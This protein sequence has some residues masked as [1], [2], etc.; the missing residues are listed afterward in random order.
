[1]VKENHFR[2]DRK[3]FFNFWKTIYGFAHTLDIR[4]SESGNGQNP[5]GAGIRQHSA[6]GILL[7]PEFG[8]IRL[9]F[10]KVAQNLV[11]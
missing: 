10:Q 7:M 9:V 2:F 1:M 8:D 5:G 11:F 3:S 6:T 4:L